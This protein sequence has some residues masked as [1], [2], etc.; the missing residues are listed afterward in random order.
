[1]K[2][3]ILIVI[4]LATLQ[5][6]KAAPAGAPVP[7]LEFKP[8]MVSKQ[9]Y[10]GKIIA[11]RRWKDKTGEN[12][13]ILTQPDVQWK[14]VY[15]ATRNARLY[16]YHFIKT[17]STLKEIW[18]MN[19]TVYDCPFEIRCE[20]FDNS[21]TVTDLDG[22][23]TAEVAFVYAYGCTGST[24]PYEK[25]LVLTEGKDQYVI[26]GSTLVYKEKKKYGGDKEVPKKFE[27]APDAF[28]EFANK[29]WDKFGTAKIHN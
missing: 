9:L 29:Q 28:L 15:E 26:K 23:G 8:G 16:A 4:L 27:Q 12:I 18:N 13:V 10:K 17:D 7:L 24:D 22:D 19:E 11:G 2:C 6:C 20:F 5:S 21:L 25:K 3:Q 1:M 14:D